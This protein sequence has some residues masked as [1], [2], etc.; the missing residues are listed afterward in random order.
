VLEQRRRLVAAETVKEHLWRML[1]DW[2]RILGEPPAAPAMAR[3]LAAFR[4]LRGA[5][6]RDGDPFRPGMEVPGTGGAVTALGLADLSEVARAQ[7][8]GMAAAEWLAGVQDADALFDWAESTPTPAARL[9][10]EVWRKGWADLGRSDVA[11]LPPLCAQE[12]EASLGGQ[13]AAAFVAEPTWNGAAA[14]SSPFTRNLSH[15]LVAGLAARFGNGL[16]PRLAAQLVEL[17]RL[18]NELTA[19]GEA[20]LGADRGTASTAPGI[21]IAQAQAARGLLVHRVAVTGDRVT[22][23][24]ILAPTEWNFH[25]RGAVA[26]GLAVL[27]GEDEGTLRRLAGLFVTAVD[28]CVEYDLS[29]R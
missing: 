13:D 14:E 3:G 7:V 24:R 25:P 29:I 1:L 5:F 15:P 12:I 11:A 21:G 8:L 26:A 6:A 20:P 22:D 19:G 4:R 10:G 23:Y 17:A 9:L 27:P 2:P 28:P 16:L 18:L